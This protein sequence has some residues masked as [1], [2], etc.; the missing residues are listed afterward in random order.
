MLL[1]VITAI[2]LS[3]HEVILA[4]MQSIQCATVQALKWDKPLSEC[5]FNKLNYYQY[6]KLTHLKR[7]WCWERLRIEGE[8]GSREDE[9]FGWHHQLNGIT[10][11]MDMGLGGPRELVMGREAWHGVEKSWTQLSNWTELN[12]HHM[13]SFTGQ[14]TPWLISIR[15]IITSCHYSWF[16][17]L[18]YII[19]THI[20]Y[21][22][23][24]VTNSHTVSEN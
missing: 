4:H 19:Y 24:C 7:L 15:V 9:I 1:P 21:M 16:P 8:G 14:L 3:L 17:C 12:Y 11:W 2:Q 13:Q 6:I 5:K 23:V 10:N 22:C 20:L 18:N